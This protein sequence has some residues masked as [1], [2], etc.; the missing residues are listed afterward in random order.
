M[1]RLEAALE[2]RLRDKPWTVRDL[3]AALACQESTVHKSLSVLRSEG[4]AI[5]A[6]PWPAGRRGP[7]VGRHPMRYSLE[8]A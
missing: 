5:R 4:L 6:V 1:G 3:A 7:T 2:W 8:D